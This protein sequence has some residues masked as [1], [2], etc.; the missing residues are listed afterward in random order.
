MEYPSRRDQQVTQVDQM[1]WAAA[2]RWVRSSG[3]PH[4]GYADSVMNDGPGFHTNI[5]GKS[6][7]NRSLESSR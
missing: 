7:L 4:G 2:E 6:F 1:A 3:R 5:S